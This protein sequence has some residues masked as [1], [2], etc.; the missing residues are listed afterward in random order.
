VEVVLNHDGKVFVPAHGERTV[1]TSRHHVHFSATG[2]SSN[3]HVVLSQTGNVTVPQNCGRHHP[4]VCNGVVK[5]GVCLPSTTSET[6][7]GPRSKSL[8]VVSTPSTGSRS[9]SLYLYGLIGLTIAAGSVM[10]LKLRRK[11]VPARHK[12]DE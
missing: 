12:S 5:N 8:V 3:G 2:Q 9:D 1:K 7:M 10:L 4:P 6:G 11:P